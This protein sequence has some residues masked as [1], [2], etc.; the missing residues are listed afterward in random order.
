MKMSTKTKSI[1]FMAL[2]AIL[3]FSKLAKFI[4]EMRPRKNAE[5]NQ[6]ISSFN[7]LN[8]KIK[9]QQ[10]WKIFIKLLTKSKIDIPDN[11]KAFSQKVHFRN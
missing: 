3:R 5:I 6:M 9:S 11:L 10:I 1:R 8:A 2:L 7:N 4:Q